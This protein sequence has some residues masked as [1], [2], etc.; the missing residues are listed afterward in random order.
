MIGIS[1][2]SCSNSPSSRLIKVIKTDGVGSTGHGSDKACDGD[3]NTYYETP[4][5][6]QDDAIRRNIDFYFNGIYVLTSLKLVNVSIGKYL[7]TYSH[8]EIYASQ[9]GMNFNKIAYKANNDLDKAEGLI[10][11]FNKKIKASIVRVNLSFNS[12]WN[13][14]VYGGGIS[15]MQGNIEEINFY[16]YLSSNFPSQNKKSKEKYGQ[17][18]IKSFNDT[19]YGDFHRNFITNKTFRD[20]QTI[21]EIENLVGRI[22][23]NN[24]IQRF[25]FSLEQPST[26]KDTYSIGHVNNKIQIIGN[27]A[28]ALASGFNYYIKKYCNV[29]FN[30][31][32]SSNK[33]Q[34]SPEALPIPDDVETKT[35][36]YDL[37]YA[38]NTCTFSYTMAFW[39]WKEWQQFLDWSAMN[40]INFMLDFIGQEEV[41]R[42]MLKD[43]KYTDD[44]ARDFITGPNYFAWFWMAN[45]YGIG[46]RLPLQWFTQSVELARKIHKQMEIY[47]ITPIMQG[48]NGMVPYDFDSAL[49]NPHAR[50]STNSGWCG[51]KTNQRL[52]EPYIYPASGNYDY[53][54][55]DHANGIDIGVAQDFYE[56][57]KRIFGDIT[58][59]W[60]TDLFH[61]GN[62][63]YPD[64][65]CTPE[66]AYLN[67]FKAMKDNNPYAKWVM[68]C[69]LWNDDNDDKRVK[70][71]KAL[72]TNEDNDRIYVL[73]LNADVAS[74]KNIMERTDIQA[75]W[76]W[77]M[78][79]NFGGRM[80]IY[81]M[82][83]NWIDQ[84]PD[85]PNGSGENAHMRGIG[86]APEAFA[87]SPVLYEMLLDMNWSTRASRPSLSSYIN[88]YIKRSYN[89]TYECEDLMA[90]EDGDTD[91]AWDVLLRTAY[92]PVVNDDPNDINYQR[93]SGQQGCP[94]SVFNGRPKKDWPAKEYGSGASVWGGVGLGYKPNDFKVAL[95]K[96]LQSYNE[97]YSGGKS[98]N[99]LYDFADVLRQYISNLGLKYTRALSSSA[100]KDEF[101][102]LKNN[103]LQL[104]LLQDQVLSHIPS[105]RTSKHINA[106]RNVI[107]G[108][109]DWTKDLFEF[110]ARC[111]ITTWAGVTTANTGTLHDY[112]NR[113]WS[114]ITKTLYYDRWN[115]YFNN[116]TQSFPTVFTTDDWFSME[117][118]WANRKSDE[119]FGFDNKDNSNLNLCE[120]AQQA[121]NYDIPD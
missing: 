74:K 83:Q 6:N 29:E 119:G 25:A 5:P 65:S 108:A 88:D 118:E 2:C 10:F 115:R 55:G 37:R 57:Q 117:W 13:S 75:N 28:N 52:L 110:N 78:I 70:G 40:G 68:Q 91:G 109:D 73:D 67:V 60:S 96:F 46:G 15:G 41:Y 90:S 44:E 107:K 32:F 34:I 113:Q 38:L 98:D 106:A 64:A 62:V 101:T 85:Q 33:I 82:P 54:N 80:G 7:N 47:N 71:L 69:W 18:E 76:L 87:S 58:D 49:K 50:V 4:P 42:E 61:E 16:G 31:M 114:G 120:L 97:V 104:M 21:K 99:F 66:Q 24:Y 26:T 102:N 3:L 95:D 56:I 72:K 17:P 1:G 43:F 23:G 111:S 112:S 36:N 81:G 11:N 77:C 30:P 105:W 53:F 35:A 121:L 20:E 94:E 39:D 100:T 59:Y 93:W 14:S 86:I 116:T 89:L 12:Y 19:S 103:F 22:L 8:Y 9:D 63:E 48:F 51:F 79:N 45:C 84:V 27:N 92:N